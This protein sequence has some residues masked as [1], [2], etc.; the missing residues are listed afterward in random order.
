MEQT[1]AETLNMG[2]EEPHG[3][4]IIG[5]CSRLEITIAKVGR[6]YFTLPP[7]K[8][9]VNSK[10]RREARSPSGISDC[11]EFDA[12]EARYQFVRV[13]GR[14]AARRSLEMKDWLS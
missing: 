13:E 7:R 12:A 1:P 6:I 5:P 10:R 14:K 4:N 2:T 8:P 3:Q 11:P 9:P